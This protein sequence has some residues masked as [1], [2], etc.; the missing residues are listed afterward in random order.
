MKMTLLEI[1]QSIL[2]DMDGEEVNSLGDTSEATQIASIVRDTF[3]N[4]VTNRTIPEHKELLKF[5]SYSDMELPTHFKYEDNTKIEKVWYKVDGD[6]KEIKWLEPMD[7]LRQSDTRT[8]NYKEVLDVHAG[9][10]LRITNDKAPSYYTSFDDE[11][12]VMD[13]YE[14]V[15]ETTL[16]NSNVR[17]YGVVPPTFDMHDD[18]FVPDIDANLFP[19]FLAEAKSTAFSLLHGGP[20]P[21]VEQAARRQKYHLQN[22]KHN[23]VTK[24]KLS[25]YGR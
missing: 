12:I 23:T 2:S 6:Y 5:T 25:N 17:A 18:N 20:D 14:N 24:R 21:K 16:M 22:D 13:A 15:K 19:Y 3:F 9:T 11:T 7:F 4:M 10:T 1:T 8:G